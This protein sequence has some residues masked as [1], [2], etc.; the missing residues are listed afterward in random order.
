MIRD[1]KK[2]PVVADFVGL[3]LSTTLHEHITV[4]LGGK[5]GCGVFGLEKSN[6]RD[7]TMR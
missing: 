4:E 3:T 2:Y 1:H 7:A 6:R 5:K